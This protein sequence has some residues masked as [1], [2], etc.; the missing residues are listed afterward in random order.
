[1]L[2]FTEPTG[3]GRKWQRWIAANLLLDV[4]VEDI[5][6]TL[7]E[8]GLPPDRATREVDAVVNNVSLPAE[9]VLAERLE[10]AET[11]LGVLDEVARRSPTFGV[12]E[13]KSEVS[14]EQFFEDYYSANRPLILSGLMKNWAAMKTWSPDYFKSRFGAVEIEVTTNRDADPDYEVNIERHRERMTLGDYVEMVKARVTNDHYVIARNRLFEKEGLSDLLN[15]I[16]MFP[17]YLDPADAAGNVSLWFGPAGTITALHHD[18]T[19][20][21][22]AQVHG[23]KRIRLVPP[24]QLKLVYCRRHLYSEVDCEKPDLE[25][26]PLFAKA[27][28]ME[29][30]LNPGEVL[31]IPVGWW[32]DVRALDISMSISFNN[33]IVPNEPLGYPARWSLERKTPRDLTKPAGT[34]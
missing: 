12:I 15:D 6:R 28:V 13:R 5:K 23:R 31:F 20:M 8:R 9:S 19:N 34:V 32:H 3:L 25:K 11:V 21:L 30:I 24:T 26:H 27:T 1:M 2:Q 17:Q 29:L 14:K 10:K 22:L 7:V 18:F 33:F 4:A 16:E